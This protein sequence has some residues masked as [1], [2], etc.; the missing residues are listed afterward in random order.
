MSQQNP[1]PSASTNPASQQYPDDAQYGPRPP[2]PLSPGDARTWSVLSHL[3]P[4][5]T[6]L[7]GLSFLGPLV[8]YLVLRDRSDIVRR[9]SAEALNFQLSL[10]VYAVVGGLAT[11]ILAMVTFG[12]A[13][14]PLIFLVPAAVVAV[15]VFMVIAAI[16]AGE[17]RD[18]RYP[19]TL[20]LVS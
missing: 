12:I 15:V 9:H 3:S 8:V 18:Y 5:L 10:L 7:L 16:R 11:G 1:H 2:A 13:V 14:V 19:L 4:I 20:R 17:D 6:V